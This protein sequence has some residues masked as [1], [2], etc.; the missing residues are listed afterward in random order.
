MVWEWLGTL[1]WSPERPV[2]RLLTVLESETQASVCLQIC[3]WLATARPK[4]LR[5]E[6]KTA[7]LVTVDRG[8]SNEEEGCGA[9][10][11]DVPQSQWESS[12]VTPLSAGKS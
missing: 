5:W 7:A 9:G 11:W 10:G 3:G 12:E 6:V 4:S 8:R 2:R 1:T